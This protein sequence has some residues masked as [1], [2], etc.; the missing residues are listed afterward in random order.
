[1]ANISRV[2]ECRPTSQ[3]RRLAC[4]ARKLM[5]ISSAAILLVTSGAVI[6]VSA[7]SAVPRSPASAPKYASLKYSV[8]LKW[9]QRPTWKTCPAPRWIQPNTKQ[10]QLL[11]QK[12]GRGNRIVVVGDS[13]TREAYWRIGQNLLDRGWLPTIVCWGGKETNWGLQQ[14]KRLDKANRMPEYVLMAIGTNDMLFRVKPHTFDKRVKATVRYLH[15]K[16]KRMWWVNTSFVVNRAES[17]FKP[18][19]AQYRTFNTIISRNFSAVAPRGRLIDWDKKIARNP[20]KYIGTDGIHDT[21]AGRT[22]RAR[23]ISQIKPVAS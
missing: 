13:L 10:L 7:T 11:S 9:T 18:R 19:L 4:F 21:N 2:T 15:G 16:T 6:G 1:M 8:A 12:P 14:L 3:C 23:L 20:R 5:A 22:L 17:R